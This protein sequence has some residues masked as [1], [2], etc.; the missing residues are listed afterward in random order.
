[1]S[2]LFSFL[3]FRGSSQLKKQSCLPEDIFFSV[4]EQLVYTRGTINK[5]KRNSS[6]SVYREETRTP[7]ETDSQEA[8]ESISLVSLWLF[9]I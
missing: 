3:C 4:R 6:H 2:K 1:M 5:I 7:Y 8:R 9:S